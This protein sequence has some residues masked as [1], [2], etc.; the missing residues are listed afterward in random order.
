MA[1]GRG[2]IEMVEQSG[3]TADL[4]P[5]MMSLSGRSENLGLMTL[6]DSAVTAEGA[7]ST[8]NPAQMKQPVSLYEM[9]AIQIGYHPAGETEMQETFE[10]T[11]SRPSTSLTDFKTPSRS[12]SHWSTTSVSHDAHEDASS[13]LHHGLVEQPQ[14]TAVGPT[15]LKPDVLEEYRTFI[16]TFILGLLKDKL[17]YNFQQDSSA[18]KSRIGQIETGIKHGEVHETVRPQI[19]ALLKEQ[20]YLPNLLERY[21]SLQ[22]SAAPEQH[23]VTPEN[24]PNA[25]SM[26][27]KGTHVTDIQWQD[28]LFDDLFPKP[29]AAKDKTE[30]NQPHAK[31]VVVGKNTMGKLFDDEEEFADLL[32]PRNSALNIKAPVVIPSPPR[33][34]LP[35]PWEAQESHVQKLR[36]RKEQLGRKLQ[37]VTQKITTAELLMDGQKFMAHPKTGHY[38]EEFE[39][40]LDKLQRRPEEQKNPSQKTTSRSTGH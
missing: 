16:D 32:K 13:E 10:D 33:Q 8:Q 20:H 4:D 14:K 18:F 38:S 7:R 23:A 17:E 5:H 19:V 35:N 30:D 24:T 26:S 34:P 1:K 11:H 27:I 36:E 9:E 12:Q 40:Y 6:I 15:P 3:K 25:L 29:D 22:R 28:D 21:N 2:D 39:S 31:S 37:D